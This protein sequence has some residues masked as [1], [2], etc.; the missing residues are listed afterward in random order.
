[1]TCIWFSDLIG[2]PNAPALVADSLTAT[3]LSLFWEAPN[4]GNINYLVQWRYEEL[5]GTWQYY[6]NISHSNRSIIYVENLQPYTKYRVSYSA[7]SK[8]F[9]YYYYNNPHV[10]KILGLL[11]YGFMLWF[12]VP[13][14]HISLRPWRYRGASEFS[15]FG[16]Y[17][18]SRKW[19]T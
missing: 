19:Q 9:S 4:L 14:S 15:T 3:S 12:S 6:S 13:S 8:Y 11:T 7:F 10:K 5:P 17:L 18:Y 16:S 2:T 1:M